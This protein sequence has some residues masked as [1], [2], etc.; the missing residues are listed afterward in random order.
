MADADWRD[1]L[2]GWLG[3]FLAALR[4]GDVAAAARKLVHAL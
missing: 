3:P 2:N 4:Q 1:E